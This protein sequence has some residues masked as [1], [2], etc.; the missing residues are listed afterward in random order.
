MEQVR[1][2]L[3]IYA[4]VK[5]PQARD[6][7]THSEFRGFGIFRKRIGTN[8]GWSVHAFQRS[9]WQ[10]VFAGELRRGDACGRGAAA[11]DR[12]EVGVGAPGSAGTRDRQTGTVPTLP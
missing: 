4:E 5:A 2:P 7:G 9:G 12:G 11:R 3:P 8:L 10:S 6:A 1:S